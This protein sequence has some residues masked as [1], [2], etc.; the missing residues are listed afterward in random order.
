MLER[1]VIV[2]SGNLAEAL[3]RAVAQCPDLRL[4]QL[5]A[6]NAERGAE[7]ARLASTVWTGNP[8]RLAAADL[9]IIAVSDRAVGEVAA[10][11]AFPAGAAVVHTAG[12][13][14]L[15]ALPPQIVRRGV[16]YPLQ[17]F[18][19]GRAVDFERIPLFIEASDEGLAA[20][21]E[22]VA[23]CL[24][25]RVLAA[26]SQR[27]A[28]IHLAGVLANNFANHMYLLGERV[29]RGAGLEFDDLKPLIAETAAKALAASS[30]AEVQ[31]G[32]AVR[33]DR[34]TIERHLAMLAGDEHLHD[35]YESISQSIW[36]ISRKI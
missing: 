36:E 3:A 31:T 13:V 8:A 7:V 23:R 16:F 28:A 18:T 5:F 10:S 21:L 17:T 1:I 11:L 32:P 27:R 19:R 35:L 9:Y 34:A 25:R 30:P 12:S 15:E 4:V 2:G 22:A 14:A 6:R 20:E 26:D 24:S 29:A 33:H